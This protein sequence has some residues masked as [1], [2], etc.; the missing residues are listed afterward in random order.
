MVDGVLSITEKQAMAIM[1]IIVKSIIGK[2]NDDTI[3]YYCIPGQPLNKDIN[4]EYHHKIIQAIL[5]SFDMKVKI[6]GCPINEA[7]AIVI[8][9]SQDKTAIGVSCGAGMVNVCYCLYGVPIYEFSLVG[10][11]DLIDKESSK[12]TG[13]PTSTITRIKESPDMHLD[14]GLPMDFVKKAIYLNYII[15]IERIAK[16][17]ASGFKAN[18]NRAKAPKPMPI[19]IAGG[20]ASIAGFHALFKEVLAKQDMP[21]EVGE[22]ILADKPLYAVAEGCL[23]AAEMHEEEKEK[24]G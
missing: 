2:L 12:V 24:K 16:G 8:S 6:N 15:L 3:L 4:V 13:E 11:G 20:T 17:I 5:E 23:I 19:I 21:F 18:E 10:A 14:T 9:R 1:G 7:R 22:V